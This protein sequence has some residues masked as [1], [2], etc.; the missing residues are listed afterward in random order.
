VL[1]SA[2]RSTLVLIALVGTAVAAAGGTVSWQGQQ[3]NDFES[4][5][6]TATQADD[7]LTYHYPGVYPTGSAYPSGNYVSQCT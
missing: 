1:R 3:W 2:V 4:A 7:V 5:G 6:L